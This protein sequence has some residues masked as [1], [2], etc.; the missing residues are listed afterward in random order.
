[1]RV[2]LSWAKEYVDLVLPLEG[3]NE[4]LTQ[5]GLEVGHV[6]VIGESWDNVRIGLVADVRPHPN[7]DR[8]TLVTVDLGDAKQIVVCGAPN[9]QAGQKIA[10]ASVGARL[11]DGHT[12]QAA[13]LKPARIRGVVS[14]GMVCSEKELGLSDSH[15]GIFVLPGDAPLGQPLREYLGETILDVEVTPNRPDCLSVLGVA[16]E[17]A[18]LS[19]QTVRPP[20]PIYKEGAT[21]AMF[22]AK[23]RIEAPDLCARYCASVIRGVKI[24][25]SPRWLQRRLEAC[26]M[27]SINNVV[28]A[29]NYVMLEF[30]QPLHAFD[31]DNISEK[32]I[33]VRRAVEGET[34]ISLDGVSRE[35]GPG[36]LVIADSKR[37]VAV[38][39]VMGGLNS[40][41]S[42][43]TTSVL[44]ES[45][46]FSQASIRRT[47]GALNM[48]SEASM[49]FEK[50]LPAELAV[51]ALRRATQLIAETAGGE[52]A[53]GYIDAFPGEKAEQPIPLRSRDVNRL[54]GMDVGLETTKKT[55]ESLGFVCRAVSG[56]GM[57]VSVPY[58]RT[59]VK[60]SA[61]LVEEIARI[62][63][64]DNIPTT[65]ICAPVPAYRPAPALVL[66]EKLRAV[67]TACGLQEVITY[68]LTSIENLRK[69]SVD[70]SLP[71]P[72]PVMIAN[73]MSKE[74]ECLRISLRPRLLATVAAN[75][76]YEDRI[77]LFE[78]G[79]VY[80]RREGELPSEVE[81]LAVMLYGSRHPTSWRVKD[82]PADFFDAKGIVEAALDRL[83][84]DATFV[85][86]AD[87]GMRTGRCARI[88]AGLAELGIM[89]EVHARVVEAFDANGPIY[90][91]EVDL[92]RLLSAVSGECRYEPLP[93]F[94][95]VVRDIAL[96]VDAGVRY[97][98]ISDVVK[99]QPLV[100]DVTL[101]DVYEGDR[102]EK[103]KRSIAFRV[104]YQS[105][106]TLTDEE[107]NK[108]Q[109]K[110]LEVL[111]S[112]FRA[113]LRA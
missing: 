38:A 42:D 71:G 81:T 27:R 62:I 39:G 59:D 48:R 6:D 51:H 44:L 58:W 45:A 20:V 85:A 56:D 15:E 107:V 29:T 33:I 64:Y 110:M 111:S 68:S 72:T 53:A 23:V 84:V 74:Y 14:E 91:A 112:R 52:A 97:L 17:I 24:G 98:D 13:T 106:H 73:P 75:Q 30:G 65:M 21:S 69:V 60:Q 2:P 11:I 10:F 108:V 92:H 99:S 94:P 32:Q 79:K 35:L 47:A 78:I 87:P 61:D 37:A 66:K 31:L 96:V 43:S 16:R 7:A 103:G 101:F 26:G 80:L 12:G 8:L 40:E 105:D 36:M 90:L 18:A 41:V 25:P 22:L 93:R 109:G 63:G 77:G 4:K 9:V 28:D 49:R 55:L 95:S 67:L 104:I 100:S 19:G 46:N 83:G 57:S 1:M 89:G 88:M 102:V 82:V 76:R 50:G 86:V 5:A 54:L 113:T 34:M 70:G 3:L